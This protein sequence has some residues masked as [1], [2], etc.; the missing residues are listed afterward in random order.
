MSNRKISLQVENT[1]A[2]NSSCVI[3]S[4]PFGVN[5]WVLEGLGS[6][7]KPLSV[8]LFDNSAV[9]YAGYTVIRDCLAGSVVGTIK[10]KVVN[11]S[12][13]A[14]NGEFQI[15]VTCDKSFTSARKCAGI[16]I[17]NLKFNHLYDAYAT[18]CKSI[19]ARP[20]RDA[21]E[22][23][24]NEIDRGLS[25]IRVTCIGKFEKLSKDN[26]TKAIEALSKKVKDTSAKSK[27]AK[28]VLTLKDIGAT[29][30]VSS[31][32][33]VVNAPGINGIVMKSYIDSMV[34]G[35]STI[36]INGEL[37][38]PKIKERTIHLLSDSEKIGR[39]ITQLDK[40]DDVI[41]SLVFFAATT[42]GLSSH[43]LITKGKLSGSIIN[44]IERALK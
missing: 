38:Y 14:Q 25:R 36:L 27:G 12:C 8:D 43:D 28:R 21:F 7:C 34:K 4:F 44:I 29:D 20:S 1:R 5:V 15:S 13:G 3:V 39:F 41:G 23:A 17:K 40:L 24:V 6:M 16:I 42:C 26:K 9:A 30:T 19:G 31:I 33:S 18:C 37:Y 11:M 32:Y 35:I 22:S 2:I 10:N